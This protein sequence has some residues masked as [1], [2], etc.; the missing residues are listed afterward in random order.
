MIA[1]GVLRADNHT[2]SAVRTLA[3]LI[4]RAELDTSPVGVVRAT[5]WWCAIAGDV[6]ML[7]ALEFLRWRSVRIGNIRPAICRQVRVDFGSV[8]YSRWIGGYLA[9][10]RIAVYKGG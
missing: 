6:A 8:A 7:E 3:F 5:S 9:D 10:W 4:V 2:R 1:A